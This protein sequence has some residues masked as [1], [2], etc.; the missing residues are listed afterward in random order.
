[1]QVR[2]LEGVPRFWDEPLWDAFN[3]ANDWLWHRLRFWGYSDLDRL[4]SLLEEWNKERRE[5]YNPITGVHSRIGQAAGGVRKILR[6]LNPNVETSG[7]ML[8]GSDSVTRGFHVTAPVYAVG[9]YAGFPYWQATYSFD[10]NFS[11]NAC[12]LYGSNAFTSHTV[13]GLSWLEEFKNFGRVYH[14]YKVIGAR[15]RFLRRVSVQQLKLETMAP[16]E[17]LLIQGSIPVNDNLIEKNDYTYKTQLNADSLPPPLDIVLDGGWTLFPGVSETAPVMGSTLAVDTSTFI[18][19]T[20]FNSQQ[21]ALY[22][23]S[24]GLAISGSIPFGDSETNISIHLGD[25]DVELMV[26]FS[27]RIPGYVN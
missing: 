3:Y 17:V 14:Y 23:A 26:E 12:G 1:M 6:T 4:D 8:M 21:P 19:V 15:L 25:M 2:R 13:L 5:A 27:F 9:G 18:D 11:I 20:P 10:E 22:L 24:K 7:V 16:I